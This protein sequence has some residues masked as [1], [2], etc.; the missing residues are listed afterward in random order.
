MKVEGIDHIAIATKDIKR[1]AGFY[2]AL[3]EEKV[4]EIQEVPEQDIKA[5]FV[6]ITGSGIEILQP[7]DPAG[8]IQ[9]FIDKKGEGIHHIALKITNIDG[10]INELNEKGIRLIESTTN[11][12][13]TV[14]IHPKSTGGILIELCE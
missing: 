10:A 6:P 2:E 11:G 9:C 13:K 5:I 4:G 8:S 12:K 1:T 7:I 3:L 14:F